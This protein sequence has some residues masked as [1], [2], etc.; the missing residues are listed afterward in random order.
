MAK[1]GTK[2]Y[3]TDKT[4]Q[5][6]WLNHLRLLIYAW[7]NLE[8]VMLRWRLRLVN[9]STDFLVHTSVIFIY[10]YFFG[11]LSRDWKTYSVTGWQTKASIF[12]WNALEAQEHFSGINNL[13]SLLINDINILFS[14]CVHMYT[15]SLTVIFPLYLRASCMK[16]HI[17]IL[18]EW[19]R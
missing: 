16:K 12:I 8:V 1:T 7:R 15:T 19:H 2:Q 10:L 9:K 18:C 3:S 4:R 14:L 5:E 11:S 17:K 13:L 6:K